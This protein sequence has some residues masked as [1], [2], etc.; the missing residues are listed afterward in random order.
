MR[1]KYISVIMQNHFNFYEKIFYSK[2]KALKFIKKIYKKY[3]N[4]GVRYFLNYR[5]RKDSSFIKITEIV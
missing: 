2:Y 5:N 1:K 4:S 3:T